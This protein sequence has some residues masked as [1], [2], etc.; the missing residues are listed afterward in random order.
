M[1]YEAPEA[2]AYEFQS[3]GIV[4][5]LKKLL[6]EFTAKLGQCQKEEMNSKHAYDMVIADLT[7]SIENAEKE[8]EAKTVEKEQKSEKSAS[9]KKQLSATVADKAE[10]EKLLKSTETECSEKKL[11]FAEKQ[12]L[13]KE[14][15][16][17]IAKAI[18]I[19]S[20]DDVSG[21]ADKYLSLAQ[22]QKSTS[23]VQG[24][25]RNQGIRRQIH[26]F[27]AAE[28]ARKHSKGLTLLAQQISADPFAKVKKPKNDMITRLLEEAEEDAKHEGFCDKEMGKSKITRNKLTEDIDGLEA[29]IEEGKATI[30]KL[31]DDTA[32]LTKEVEELVKSMAEATDLRTNEKATNKVTVKDAQAAQKAVA[33]AT[34]V[35]KDFYEKAATAT[36][37]M[38]AKTPNPRQWGLKTGV[39]MGTDEWNALA[40]PNFKGTVD[41]GH[42]EDMQTFGES[43]DGQQ[44][45]GHKED[46]QTFGESY[47]G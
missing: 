3:G 22:S 6:A 42:K 23:F 21:N 19:L 14:E 38:Q 20:S 45:K 31:A 30:Q 25:S 1:D 46:M 43:Y 4:D 39:K 11:S 13:R 15:L 36:A 12:K 47:D 28:G 37:L 2:N 8:I 29:T 16:E 5:L 17:A 18:E 33:A 34:A 32:T 40:N 9:N 10:N 24:G 41:K 7:D 44:D 27:L 35:L 26:D